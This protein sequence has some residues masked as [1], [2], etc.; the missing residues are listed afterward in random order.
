MKLAGNGFAASAREWN[1]FDEVARRNKPRMGP[2]RTASRKAMWALN[3]TGEF[4]RAGGVIGYAPRVSAIDFTGNEG[5]WLAAPTLDGK[6]PRLLTFTDSTNTADHRLSFAV[7]LDDIQ[8]DSVGR[9][10]V[11]GICPARVLVHD[12]QA[13]YVGPIDQRCDALQT[14]DGGLGRILQLAPVVAGESERWAV[15]NLEPN[16]AVRLEGYIEALS[17][18]TATTSSM[19][20]A[21]AR[22][23]L[24]EL[25]GSNWSRLDEFVPAVNVDETLALAP[26][27]LVRVESWRPSAYR[28]YWSACGTSVAAPQ[29]TSFVEA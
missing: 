14:C 7:A 17:R 25:R 27:T 26:G 5:Q 8:E 10:C 12:E 24:R 28:I 22:V 19:T 13:L 9:V 1:R 3:A 20:A 23:R 29:T 18:A 6:M 2:N 4:V 16:A 11:A 15:I 21:K